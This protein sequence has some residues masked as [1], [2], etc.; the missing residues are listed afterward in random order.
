MLK[1]VTNF[2]L[3]LFLALSLVNSCTGLLAIQSELEVFNTTSSKNL[4]L[5][6]VQ[7]FIDNIL[8]VFVRS[9]LQ[10]RADAKMF[11]SGLCSLVF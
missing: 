1:M 7:D 11:V 9:T 5:D 3:F 2:I 4:I 10:F 8:N 6:G